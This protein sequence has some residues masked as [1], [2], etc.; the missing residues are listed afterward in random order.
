MIAAVLRE[1]M[2]AGLAGEELIAAVERVE[3][4]ADNPPTKMDAAAE[5]RR[6][7]DRER[8]A[9]KRESLRKSADNPPTSENALSSFLLTSS[10]SEEGK[11]ESKKEK[12]RAKICPADFQPTESHFAI[13]VETGRNAD[14]VR[15]AATE[16]IEWS[17]ANSGRAVAKKTN[18]DLAFNSWLRR[19]NHGRAGQNRTSPAA[20]SRTLAQDTLIAG[21]AEALAERPDSRLGKGDAR[22]RGDS[23]QGYPNDNK[24]LGAIAFGVPFD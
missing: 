4:S 23:E 16:M 14:Q 12:A 17:H 8:M 13:G 9:R 21:M 20:G 7:Y 19:N 2:A 22:G 3:K 6:A 18:W 11:K 5:R 10:E 24:K 15:A 1:L